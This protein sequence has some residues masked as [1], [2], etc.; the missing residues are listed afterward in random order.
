[1]QAL[2]AAKRRDGAEFPVLCRLLDQVTGYKLPNCL[3][4]TVTEVFHLPFFFHG[5]SLSRVLASEITIFAVLL[6]DD[7]T[8]HTE[9]D[10]LHQIRFGEF[11]KNRT[12]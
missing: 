5:K 7:R 4:E 6:F 10:P 8:W 11:D 12:Q 1:M 2:K 3:L 9:H